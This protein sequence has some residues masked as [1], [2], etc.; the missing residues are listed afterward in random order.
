MQDKH[1]P[2]PWNFEE[3]EGFCSQIDGADGSVICCFDEDPKPADICLMAASP[4][5]L[6]A[7]IAVLEDVMNIDN[8]HSLSPAVGRKLRV[9]IANAT[10]GEP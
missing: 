2:G 6:E 3:E 4:E 10:R 7:A 9:A 5:L 1:T 8:D